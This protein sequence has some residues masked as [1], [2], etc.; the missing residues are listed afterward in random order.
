MGTPKFLTRIAV[1]SLIGAGMNV[2][3]YYSQPWERSADFFDG[4]NRGNYTKNAELW[5]GLY[6]IMP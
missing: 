5:A 4:V 1:P 2:K 6:L 3:N